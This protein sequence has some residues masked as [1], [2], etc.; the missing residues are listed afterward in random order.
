MA[1]ESKGKS[2]T[3]TDESEENVMT[4]SISP[5]D[6]LKIAPNP[7]GTVT[8]LS[9]LPAVPA[10]GDNPVPS[11]PVVTKDITLN[12]DKKTW[13]RI[14]RPTKLPANDKNVA[15]LPIIVYFH[16]GALILFSVDTVF[17]NEP[18][19]RFAS[20]LL[21]IVVSVEFRLAPE[22]KLPAA[23]DD[24]EEAMLW[25][26]KQALDPEGEP[27]LKD[28][29]DFSRCYVMGSSTGGTIAYNT[30]LRSLSLKLEPVKLSGVV[31]NQ[32]FFTGTKKTKSETKMVND[33][34]VPGS[35]IDLMVELILPT[36]SDRDHEYLNPMVKGTYRLN[37]KKL[38]RCLVRGFEGDPLLDR[39]MEFV[40][41]L[42][43][44]GVQVTAH[45][46]E[47]GFHLVDYIDPKRHLAML[48]YMKDFII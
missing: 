21:T 37:I 47:Y 38:P 14:Y 25:I 18:C 27:W 40:R 45:F 23:Y 12:A 5:Y 2:K 16:T 41:M 1:D 44:E 33:S 32:P 46:S 34:V 15:R 7:D 30:A 29:A 43:R 4:T 28:Y 20:E 39:Q 24:G 48:G 11:Q 22:N 17:D 8:R 35:V 36:G 26:K 42:I 19:T 9:C 6:L 3:S 10:T 13:V 31:L